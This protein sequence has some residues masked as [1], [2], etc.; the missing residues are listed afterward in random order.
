MD[1][2]STAAV[3]ILTG[4]G[5]A[6]YVAFRY[7]RKQRVAL[8]ARIELIRRESDD[9]AAEC[10]RIRQELAKQE[11]IGIG[12]QCDAIQQRMIKDL[13]AGKP[14]AIRTDA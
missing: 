3:I 5:A 6:L 4:I 13:S 14:V 8:A 9:L 2:F 11:G 1:I 10:G 7:E 12:R